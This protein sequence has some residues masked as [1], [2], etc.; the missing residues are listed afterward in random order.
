M[1]GMGTAQHA[2]KFKQVG[3]TPLLQAWLCGLQHARADGN[4]LAQAVQN[5]SA[6]N[7]AQTAPP[8]AGGWG[9]ATHPKTGPLL[10]GSAV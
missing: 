6:F 9:A 8:S 3:Q 10:K 7:A 1:Q 2:S 5:P 4:D